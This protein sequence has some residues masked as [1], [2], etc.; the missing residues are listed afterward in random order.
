MEGSK[1]SCGRILWEAIDVV[2]VL[3][4]QMRGHLTIFGQQAFGAVTQQELPVTHSSMA[5][6]WTYAP[7]MATAVKTWKHAVGWLSSD[8]GWQ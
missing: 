7:A 6:D 5:C 3:I 2:G 1:R 4:G 8:V